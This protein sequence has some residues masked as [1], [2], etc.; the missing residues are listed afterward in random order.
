MRV[1]PSVV[2]GTIFMILVASITASADGQLT[3]HTFIPQVNPAP[4]TLSQVVALRPFDP[5]APRLGFHL[6][7]RRAGATVLDDTWQVDYTSNETNEDMRLWVTVWE[8]PTYA[9]VD[10]Q[11]SFDVI[12]ANA[13]ED[14]AA[15][16][17]ALNVRDIG[18]KTLT[19]YCTKFVDSEL[20]SMYTVLVA[21]GR[22]S[23]MVDHYDLADLNDSAIPTGYALTMYAEIPENER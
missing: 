5:G 23:Y 22:L 6:E 1:M 2:M 9:Q 21:A 14:N 19:L 11:Y 8:K 20:F 7:S 15:C 3:G 12:K 17:Q 18:E 13:E 10:V 16:N 4:E